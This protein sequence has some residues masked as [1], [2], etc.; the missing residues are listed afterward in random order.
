MMLLVL[1]FLSLL[2]CSS[3][4]NALRYDPEQIPFNLNQNET[5]TDPLD[6]SGKWENH[7]YQ[8]SPKN[9]RF[10]TYTIFL[11]RF[12]NGDPTNDNANGTAYEHDI[13]SNQF[14]NGGD[15]EGLRGSLD[16][17]QGMG[18]KASS[19]SDEDLVRS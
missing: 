15:A 1:P 9:W 11:D 8:P 13:L 10:P 5:A 12:V 14:R 18:I 17:L 6:Y 19:G 4:V 16:Y 7:T 3:V 2:G